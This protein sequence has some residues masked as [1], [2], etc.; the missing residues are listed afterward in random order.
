[1]PTTKTETTTPPEKNPPP[2]KI[3][4]LSYDIDVI[5][6]KAQMDKAR[7]F[8]EVCTAYGFSSIEE[9][10]IMTDDT[11]GETT[12]KDT[13]FHELNHIVFGLTGVG[14]ELGDRDAEE[15]L[16]MMY[17]TVMFDTLRRNPDLVR[18]LFL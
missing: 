5:I 17:S 14:T 1:M 15:K 7:V 4:V 8:E 9:Q 2:S 6:D 3:N 11:M 10:Q 18:Y 13:V 16:I 12:I